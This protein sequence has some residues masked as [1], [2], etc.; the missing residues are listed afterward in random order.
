MHSFKISGE[1]DNI[2]RVVLERLE[3]DR[4]DL[5]EPQTDWAALE[6]KGTWEAFAEGGSRGRS[7]RRRQALPN[8]RGPAW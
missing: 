6:P 4:P 1:L 5:L 8:S 2:P 7:R 3:R